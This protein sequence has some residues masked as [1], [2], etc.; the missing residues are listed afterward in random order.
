MKHECSVKSREIHEQQTVLIESQTK[1]IVSTMSTI[2]NSVIS[3]HE[4]MQALRRDFE[5][6][7]G[8]F[9]KSKIIDTSN[10]TLDDGED[11]EDKDKGLEVS[12]RYH[13]D[14][15]TAESPEIIHVQFSAPDLAC[16]APLQRRSSDCNGSVASSLPQNPDHG[17]DKA[18]VARSWVIRRKDMIASSHERAR[19]G[20]ISE[21]GIIRLESSI[22]RSEQVLKEGL[23]NEEP[24]VLTLDLETAS[25]FVPM[26]GYLWTG[27]QPASDQIS[28]QD[29]ADSSTYIAVESAPVD[30]KHANQSVESMKAEGVSA[31]AVV[32]KLRQSQQAGHIRMLNN[33]AICS[34][35]E[36]PELVS[37][38]EAVQAD[39]VESLPPH[40]ASA[41]LETEILESQPM[42]SSGRDNM[43]LGS[44][45]TSFSPTSSWKNEAMT[46]L[47]ETGDANS[48]DKTNVLNMSSQRSQ[49]P[50]QSSEDADDKARP[51]S[52][53]KSGIIDTDSE[54]SILSNG[55]TSGVLSESTAGTEKPRDGFTFGEKLMAGAESCAWTEDP[56]VIPS[57]STREKTNATLEFSEANDTNPKQPVYEIAKPGHVRSGEVPASEQHHIDQMAFQD[58][59]HDHRSDFA[60]TGATE[61]SSAVA[62]KINRSWQ[63]NRRTS[64]A[65]EDSRFNPG[66]TPITTLPQPEGL[67]QEVKGNDDL[68]SPCV[69]LVR[70]EPMITSTTCPLVLNEDTE[71]V[72]I[73]RSL[74]SPMT[75]QNLSESLDH[76]S[77]QI[78]PKHNP[79]GASVDQPRLL[80]RGSSQ[81]GISL[82]A[83]FPSSVWIPPTS[84][85]H[86]SC[87]QSLTQGRYADASSLKRFDRS[88]S[89]AFSPLLD[90]S[91][92]D[93]P[94]SSLPGDSRGRKRPRT[95]SDEGYKNKLP[96]IQGG[97]EAEPMIRSP[98][99][100]GE[101]GSAAVFSG[102]FTFS[103]WNDIPA[104][105]Q[106]ETSFGF[107]EQGS[108]PV[109]SRRDVDNRHHSMKPVVLP[110]GRTLDKDKPTQSTSEPNPLTQDVTVPHA[111][112][113]ALNTSSTSMAHDTDREITRCE[114][115]SSRQP[116]SSTLEEVRGLKRPR[117]VFDDG[118]MYMSKRP[119]SK[120]DFEGNGGENGPLRDVPDLD[121]DRCERN[122]KSGGVEAMNSS[123]PPNWNPE[124]LRSR[125]SDLEGVGGEPSKLG[126]MTLVSANGGWKVLVER[127]KLERERTKLR[128]QNVRNTLQRS[129]RET[130]TRITSVFPKD[131]NVN[132][133]DGHSTSLEEGGT[134]ETTRWFTAVYGEHDD[135]Q[136][137]S[138][139]ESKQ[140][141]DHDLDGAQ[142][143]D[144]AKADVS[145]AEPTL[146]HITNSGQKSASRSPAVPV[147]SS[148][149]YD[150]DFQQ[151]VGS[152]TS[153]IVEYVVID[154]F[155]QTVPELEP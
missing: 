136:S 2:Q 98:D 125:G 50:I 22:D 11:L 43:F 86:E 85:D 137:S 93:Q 135:L 17:H 129:R 79:A 20:D 118:K 77:K 21:L 72:N 52:S 66:E 144:L 152:G 110:G 25:I 150:E 55:A 113:R 62:D 109:G 26:S 115:P 67:G 111:Q 23:S 5:T 97:M 122:T 28:V 32:T 71:A 80:T 141:L 154:N 1:A 101:S 60:D 3:M 48:A 91:S 54:A 53:G 105:F 44:P 61:S 116:A 75:D 130:K 145:R 35:R 134:S 142:S 81:L 108:N 10:H 107:D 57:E 127:N 4:E 56:D 92:L 63:S 151:E 112:T 12:K 73:N 16:N 87:E 100:G 120:S 19:T 102:P 88:K 30:F 13:H 8:V 9:A 124:I 45:L 33:V 132:P 64:Q 47:L 39:V 117:D 15:S 146:E 70:G 143:N 114:G 99:D 65:T 94:I 69:G 24:P 82:S 139:V 147:L 96:K 95:M 40:D 148:D 131:L 155:S 126:E 153:E 119:R 18:Q 149:G 14:G 121:I 89:D 76:V 46:V 58:N 36:L 6:H 106:N 42:L 133:S 138:Q 38:S 29:T 78:G 37:A 104:S 123:S 41:A 7:R 140:P 68:E 74:G 51:E 103:S 59:E 31:S 27:N 90:K 128:T 84:E 83:P 34:E 49:E